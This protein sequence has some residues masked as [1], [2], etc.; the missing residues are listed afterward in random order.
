MSYNRFSYTAKDGKVISVVEWANMENPKGVVQISH[1]MAEHILRY[2]ETA[3]KLNSV[4]YIVFGDDHR[5]FGQTD[6]NTL[7]YDKGDIWENTLSDMHEL[8]LLYKERY[9]G[10]PFVLLGHSYGSFLLQ[11]Y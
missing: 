4:G 7:G 3:E 2:E 5:A 11:A 9:K 8:T 10:L 6:I 1:G